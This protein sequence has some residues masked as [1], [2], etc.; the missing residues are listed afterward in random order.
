MRAF[1]AR[2]PELTSQTA[3][4]L[5]KARVHGATPESIGAFFQLYKA[6]YVKHNLEEKPHPIYNCDETGF[7]DE[8]R[9]REK[10]LCQTGRKH[11]YQQQ[12]T[13]KEHI[14]VH[15]CVNASGDTIPPFIMWDLG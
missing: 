1:K 14:T 12:Q 4:S 10:V 8:P 13:T 11:V 7:G 6:L 2:H 3:D 15:C 9:S 5:D